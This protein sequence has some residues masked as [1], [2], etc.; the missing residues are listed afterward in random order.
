MSASDHLGPQFY[1]YKRGK[2]PGY[3]AVVAADN[4]GKV[5]GHISWGPNDN[6]VQGVWV[7]PGAR[8]QGIATGLWQHASS[9]GAEHHT[10]RTD[11]GDAW[12][13]S[14][15]AVPRTENSNT[16]EDIEFRGEWAAGQHQER[17]D[18]GMFR[19]IE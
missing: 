1:H 2:N 17:L 12:A 3:N 10:D 9:M 4:S 11:A 14:L 13:Q 19:P 8:R 16:S 5:R 18:R 6:R 7:D 15:G